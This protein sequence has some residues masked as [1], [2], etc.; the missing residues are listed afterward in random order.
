MEHVDPYAEAPE[1]LTKIHKAYP[2]W[3]I[4]T[5]KPTLKPWS[6]QSSATCF[7]LSS[8]PVAR[9]SE[10]PETADQRADPS[11]SAKEPARTAIGVLNEP[12]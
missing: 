12:V 9:K 4:E 11:Q 7:H 3:Q 10:I 8:P 5:K 2:K 6:H 1:K